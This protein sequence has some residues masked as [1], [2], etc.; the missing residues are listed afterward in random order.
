MAT[1]VHQDKSTLKQQLPNIFDRGRREW[2]K[3]HERRLSEDTDSEPLDVIL[4]ILE[5]SWSSVEWHLEQHE[6]FLSPYGLRTVFPDVQEKR[7]Q[8]LSWLGSWVG[9]PCQESWS[10]SQLQFIVSQAAQLHRYRGTKIGL[11][12][13][14]A[15]FLG[16]DVSIKEWEWPTGMTIGYQSTHVLVW[17]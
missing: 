2:N 12:Y 6:K 4:E 8:F 14:I 16:L 5:E 13:T 1:T 17:H 11:E 10:E 15:L 3:V 7:R 9:V